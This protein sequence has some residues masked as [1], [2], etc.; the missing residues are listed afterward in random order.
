MAA[1]GRGE[2]SSTGQ[3]VRALR[4]QQQI[5]RGGEEGD[6]GHRVV[7]VEGRAARRLCVQRLEGLI[8]CGESSAARVPAVL[9]SASTT[10]SAFQVGNLEPEPGTSPLAAR[11]SLRARPPC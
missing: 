8:P 4:W 2:R 6:E 9:S 5:D 11:P 10:A 3:A 7:K 1:A